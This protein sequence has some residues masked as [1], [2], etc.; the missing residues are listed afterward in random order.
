MKKLLELFSKKEQLMIFLTSLVIAFILTFDE[1]G[2]E[3][4]DVVIGLGNLLLVLIIAIISLFIKISVQKY[5][6]KKRGFEAEFSPWILGFVVGILLI[7]LTNGSFVFLAFGGLIFYIVEKLRLGEIRPGVDLALI[8]WISILGPLTNIILAAIVKTFTFLP[9]ALILKVISVNFWMALYGLLPIP[10]IHKF[11]V[12]GEKKFGTSDGLKLL[13]ASPL[14][15][16][17]V[18]VIMIINMVIVVNADKT[19]SL[20]TTLI[21]AVLIYIT[22]NLFYK[23]NITRR[24]GREYKYRIE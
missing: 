15:Y 9:N 17:I 21:C 4:F 20:L 16:A 13:Y 12:G 23:L 2:K 19:I 11:K 8:G 14:E 6:S 24:S 22:Y 5:F 10:F 1:W 7:I 18:L 3:T